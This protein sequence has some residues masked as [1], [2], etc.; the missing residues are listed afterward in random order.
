MVSHICEETNQEFMGTEHEN[1]FYHDTFFLMT[2]NEAMNW[3]DE[4]GI[5]KHWILPKLR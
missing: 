5:L 3:M 4:K 1:N 2:A